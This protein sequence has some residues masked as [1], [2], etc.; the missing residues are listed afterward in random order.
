MLS[1]DTLTRAEAR[2]P[3]YTSYPTAPHF[4][5][6][7][8]PAQVADWYRAIP[9]CDPVSLYVHVPF[10]AKLCWYCGCNTSI[11][12]KYQP[13][14]AYLETLVRELGHARELLGRKAPVSHLHFGGGTPNAL[15]P[16]D[17]ARLADALHALFEIE[18]HT[19]F[20]IELDPRTLDA[21][22]AWTLAAAGVTRVNLGIQDFDPAVQKA[23][24]RIQ[25][26][27]EVR[28]RL[29]EL[30]VAGISNF[31]V[32][33]LYGLPH[34]DESTIAATVDSV[35]DLGAS[36]VALFGYA[37]VPWMKPHQK[38][39]EP[40][41]LP[42]PEA[43]MKLM[44][45]AHARLAARGY[46]R[47]GI[48]HFARPDDELAVALKE[49]RL[50]R[51]FQGYTTDGARTL[52]GFGPSAISAFRQGYAQNHTRLDEWRAGVEGK[53]LPVARGRA[54]APEDRLRRAI[55]ERLMCDMKVD[56]DAIAEELGLEE[57]SERHFAGELAR[58]DRFA[59]E[60]LCVREGGR[61]AIPPAAT[62]FARIVASA[63]DAY[64]DGGEAKHSVAV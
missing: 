33:L 57:A 48:D 21:K 6:T 31:G 55:I 40:E 19:S 58:V 62:S 14:H 45:R 35:A 9:E 24:N 49:G 36:R 47:V 2:V 18:P 5:K 32:D 20:D 46:V 38:L 34:Q 52:L 53:A 44:Q 60:G 3:R 39:L 15:S 17:F 61:I 30:R 63:F 59:A 23:I 22:M 16:V 51:N 37:H 26:F 8:G 11:A 41:G 4:G 13:V 7:I 56:L 29:D 54:L 42:G 28:T 64:L 10:C 1:Q 27:A 25:T 12:T 50:A 43:R